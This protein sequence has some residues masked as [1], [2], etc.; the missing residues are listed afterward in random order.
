MSVNIFK[1]HLTSLIKVKMII[2]I[3]DIVKNNI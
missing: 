1:Q 3:H 2:N